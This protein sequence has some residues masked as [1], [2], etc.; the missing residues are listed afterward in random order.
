[1][2]P[3][4]HQALLLLAI[5][6]SAPV[7]SVGVGGTVLC[8]GAACC[9]LAASLLLGRDQGRPSAGCVCKASAL[10]LL[11]R[12]DPIPGPW[13]PAGLGIPVLSQAGGSQSWQP[14]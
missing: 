6:Q 1:M 14:C 5:F 7:G 2:A 11:T 12:A 4:G 3:H 13:P 8:V 10:L 9:V